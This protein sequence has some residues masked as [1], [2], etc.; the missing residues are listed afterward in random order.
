[1]LA[2]GGTKPTNL[3]FSPYSVSVAL[4]MTN[5]GAAGET[6]AQMAN[7]LHFPLRRPRVHPA[8]KA[9]QQQLDF[10]GKHAGFELRVANRL[11]GQKGLRFCPIFCG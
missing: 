11:W 8:L 9:I 4:A 6:E 5:A 1:M 3:F 2:C 7:V 10:K